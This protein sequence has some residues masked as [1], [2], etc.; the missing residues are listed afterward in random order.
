MSALLNVPE[1]QPA[2]ELSP[3]LS[4]WRQFVRRFF[5]NGPAVFGLVLVVVLCAVAILAPHIAPLDPYATYPDG[6]TPQG[7]PLP[8][9]W[10][11]GHFFL[12]TDP[13]GRDVLSQLIWGARV[14]ME[15]GF[16]ATLIA[17]AIGLLIGLV[18]GYAGGLVDNVLMR[19]TDIVLAFPFLLFVILLR[20]VISNPTVATVYTVIGV[21]GWAPT[22]RI[23][24]GQVLAAKNQEYVEAAR[25]LG[26]GTARIL[27][28][29]LLPNVLGTVIV[30]GTLQVAQ[31][32]LTESALSFL[33]IG[34]PDPTVSWG[35]MITLGL[36]FYQTAPWLIIWPGLALALA[37][38]GFNLLGDGLS[39]AFNPRAEE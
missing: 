4:P 29:H 5:R 16:M 23:T 13:S 18:A 8:P 26:A 7:L 1:A 20:S 17:V 15:V 38:L 28:R 21:L 14:S 11:W 32:I 3:S 34:V 37:S 24:R 19:I 35:K 9:T 36:N 25:A 27:W 39:D 22:A 2:T 30:Y 6:T 33:S 31:N 10:R 12:G